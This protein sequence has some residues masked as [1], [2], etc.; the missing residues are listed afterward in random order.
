MEVAHLFS[1]AVTAQLLDN[2]YR[3]PFRRSCIRNPLVY[4]QS[5]GSMTDSNQEG[6]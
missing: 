1:W 6:P 2:S 5:G 3:Y 4:P